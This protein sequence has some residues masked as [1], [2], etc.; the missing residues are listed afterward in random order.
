MS[1]C[2]DVLYVCVFFDILSVE[3]AIVDVVEYVLDCPG[4]N[5]RG[6]CAGN[7]KR[8]H[9]ANKMLFCILNH[10]KLLIDFFA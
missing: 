9:V 10:V 7:M 6:H 5:I 1:V 2:A 4:A 8:S 3:T